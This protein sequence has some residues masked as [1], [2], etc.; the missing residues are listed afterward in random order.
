MVSTILIAT[1][2]A[3]VAIGLAGI[4]LRLLR[5]TRAKAASAP[6]T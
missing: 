4:A 6:P 1:G 2:A 3:L 5:R